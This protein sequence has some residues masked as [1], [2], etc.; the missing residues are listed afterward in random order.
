[1]K[2]KRK[3]ILIN[4]RFQLTFL[5][6]MLGLSVVA[7]GVFYIANL[8]FFW[9]F[10][11]MGVS[12]H[13]PANHVF[14]QFI[15]DQKHTMNLVFAV[16]AAVSFFALILG[17][18]FISHRVS[19]PLHRLHQHM[20]DVAAGKTTD[21][22]QFRKGDFFLELPES[23]NQQLNTLKQEKIEKKVA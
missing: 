9:K 5:A 6:Y 1:M 15:N 12:L 21:E 18:L 19:G 13:L 23:Y 20:L 2:F 17:G 4:P 7:V 10:N 3:V 14:F 8:Y 11:S 22:V 16:T